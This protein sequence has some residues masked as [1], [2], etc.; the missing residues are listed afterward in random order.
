MISGADYMMASSW[1]D[2]V[3]VKAAPKSL[4]SKEDMD[5]FFNLYTDAATS[6]QLRSV[7]DLSL[8]NQTKELRE[9]IFAA[10]MHELDEAITKLEDEGEI[11][12][13]ARAMAAKIS[14][15]WNSDIYHA[16]ILEVVRSTTRLL[17]NP[18]SVEHAEYFSRTISKMDGQGIS[19]IL[20]G[21]A[22]TLLSLVTLGACAAIALTMAGIIPLVIGGLGAFL[23]APVA[24]ASAP[25]GLISGLGGVGL[26]VSGHQHLSMRNSMRKLGDAVESTHA[27]VV[28]SDETVQSVPAATLKK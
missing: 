18:R 22:A 11:K 17:Q 4:L 27:K 13:A 15:Y 9:R 7:M 24:I 1:A 26:F 3:K 8:V 21:V 5:K 2:D 19:D 14:D 6:D 28:G 25:I 23:A 10:S 12:K 16:D 20:W